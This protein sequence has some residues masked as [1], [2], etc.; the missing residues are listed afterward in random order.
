MLKEDIFKKK[1]FK[2]FENIFFLVND[3]VL[4]GSSLKNVLQKN[5]QTK[6]NT[7]F[8]GVGLHFYHFSLQQTLKPMFF[9]LK[10]CL[11]YVTCFF[12]ICDKTTY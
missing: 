6:E 12:L 4:G 11:K 3:L 9:C 5:L 1:L 8:L 2:I 7:L 10:A